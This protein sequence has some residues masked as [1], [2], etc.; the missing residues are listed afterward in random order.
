MQRATF[1]LSA[2]E[3][4]GKQ[5]ACT[6]RIDDLRNGLCGYPR[7][8]TARMRFGSIGTMRHDQRRHFAGQC[9]HG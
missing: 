4:G 2:Q 3:P 1:G 8:F 6:R 7:M 5:I 9:C